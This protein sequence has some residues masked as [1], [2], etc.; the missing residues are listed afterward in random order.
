LLLITS[1][2]PDINPRTEQ[3]RQDK[4]TAERAACNV[5]KQKSKSEKENEKLRHYAQNKDLCDIADDVSKQMEKS[6]NTLNSLMQQMMPLQQTTRHNSPPSSPRKRK[7]AQDSV[8]DSVG[9][10]DVVDNKIDNL[11]AKRKV[12][13]TENDE[14]EV[15]DLDERIKKYR[16]LRANMENKIFSSE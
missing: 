2:R 5:Q 9:G 3:L 15:K 12:A 13:V 16:K 7:A 10:V 1:D 11:K 8:G 4:E 14:D 6:C